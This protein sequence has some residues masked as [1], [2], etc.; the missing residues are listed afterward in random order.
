MNILICEAQL[1]GLNSPIIKKT[2]SLLGVFDKGIDGRKITMSPTNESNIYIFKDIRFHGDRY[3]IELTNDKGGFGLKI[4][5]GNDEQ[6]VTR[7]KLFNEILIEIEDFIDAKH[8]ESN[9]PP[10][11]DYF[12][13][14]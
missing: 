5:C 6:L 12:D 7:R 4:F 14:D 13:E 2:K 1:E 8:F 10:E 11:I 9:S 3:T